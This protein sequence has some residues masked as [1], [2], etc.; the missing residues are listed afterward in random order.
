MGV[1]YSRGPLP[2]KIRKRMG[3][4]SM[5]KVRSLMAKFQRRRNKEISFMKRDELFMNREE[6]QWLLEL[7]SMQTYEVFR[8]M[9]KEHRFRIGLWDLWGALILILF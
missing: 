5:V 3:N 8:L 6:V 7:T 2:P 4:I 1:K 9:D